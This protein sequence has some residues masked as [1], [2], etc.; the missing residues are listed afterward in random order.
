MSCILIVLGKLLSVLQPVRQRR[1]YVCTSISLYLSSDPYNYNLKSQ[2]PFYVFSSPKYERIY[3]IILKLI[4][5]ACINR[6]LY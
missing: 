5:V 4:N 2:D 1:E 6:L 3:V